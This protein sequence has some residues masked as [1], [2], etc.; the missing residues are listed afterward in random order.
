MPQRPS[1]TVTFL[2]SDIEGATRLLRDLGSEGY[3]GALVDHRRIVREAVATAGGTEVDTQGDAFFVAFPRAEEAARAALEIQRRL[4]ARAWPGESQ[5]RV[6]IGIHSTGAV[7]GEEGY[8]GIGVHRAARICA[9][10]HGGQT[11]VSS[12]TAD[13]LRDAEGQFALA[14]LG[15]HR[16]RDLSDSERLFQ[17]D[18]D[19][20]PDRFPPLRTLDNRPTNL[21]LQPTPLVGRERELAEVATILRR[22]GVRMVTLTGAGGSGKTRLALQAAGELLDDYVDGVFHVPLATVGDPSLVLPAIAQALGLSE[23]AGQSLPA[24][25]ASRHLLLVIDNVEQVASAAPDFAGLL[26]SAPEVRMLLTSREPMH[27]SVEHVLPVGPMAGDDAVALFAA[28]AAAARPDFVVTPDNRPIVEEI[29]ARLDRLPLAIELAA[30][31]LNVLT[32]EAM[33]ARL[34]DRLKLLTGGARDQ[35]ARHRTLRDTIAWSHDL[36]TAPERDLFACLSVFAGGFGLDAAESVCAAELDVLG[37]LVD[38][39]LVRRE[40]SRFGMLSTIREYAAER[41]AERGDGDAVRD[42][43][44]AFFV[45]LAEH[46]HAERHRH[47]GT[48]ADELA[49]D[50]DDLREA[51]DWLSRTDV[52]GFGRL[53]GALGWFWHAHSHFVEGRGRVDAAIAVLPDDAGEDRARL[54][55]AAT[56][57]AAWQGD[58]IAAERFG[59]LA[60]ESWRSLHRDVEVGLVLYD[61]GWGHFFAGEDDVARERLEASLAIQE[62]HGDPL[63]INRAQLGLLQVLVAVGDVATVKRIGP[64]ALAMSQ[65]LGDRWSEHF[66]HHFLGDCAVIEG[67]VA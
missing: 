53:A 35:P 3:G 56:E 16:L 22:E 63:L 41:L 6:R 52:R 36:L 1:G 51:L 62:S 34:A 46:A 13:L 47:P 32:P 4:L 66:A 33:L 45:E 24:Y 54:L 57:L 17:L 40:G 8:V 67:D 20:L 15:R 37:S 2:F 44:A 12:A 49:L 18:A 19:G 38:R 7:V 5:L 65:A 39:S 48:M 23:G 64:E 26:A 50:H 21:P 43:H 29:C 58:S 30:A 60:I 25:V 27:V 31:R 61:L 9:A 11:V 10:A 59:A 42:R 55:S 28:R 14:D